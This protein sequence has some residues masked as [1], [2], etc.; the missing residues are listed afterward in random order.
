MLILLKDMTLG[1]RNL[2]K[3]TGLGFVLL[4]ATLAALLALTSGCSGVASSKPSP[5][6]S[7]T[8]SWTASTSPVVGYNVYRSSTS[9]GPYTKLN[10]SP[11]TSLTYTDATVASGQSYYYV[12][13]AVDAS[14]A[15]SINSN[16]QKAVI[17]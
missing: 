16:E 10:A 4:S 2:K 5:T 1:A 15:E 3:E 13:T 9:G 12:T 14:G 7:A 6:H 11:T 8:A 17:P